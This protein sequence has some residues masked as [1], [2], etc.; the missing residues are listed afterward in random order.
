MP[1][2]SV[3]GIEINYEDKGSGDELVLIHNLTSNIE[4]LRQ[5]IAAFATRYRTIAADLRG[6]GLTT[7]ED[8]LERA[9]D[10][11]TFDNLANDQ[12]QLLDKLGV[13]RFF[14]FG[15][16]YWGANIALHLF[17]RI[18]DRVRAIVISSA[19]MISTDPGVKT[20][21]LLGET[22]R[23]N[24]IRMHQLARDKGMLAVYE[25]RKQYG[26]FWSEKVRTDPEILARFEDA[27]RHT[28]PAAFVT[29]PEISPGRRAAI[30]RLLRERRVPLMLLLGEHDQNNQQFI[31]EMRRDYPDTHTIII[32]GSGHYPT[33]ENAA[34]FNRA[35]LNFYARAA[36]GVSG[37]SV[38]ATGSGRSR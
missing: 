22:G 13:D 38:R 26:Q 18:P 9:P 23:N 33:I 4:G 31:D 25:D 30:A 16:A 32:P 12:V 5:N 2:A 24:F 36:A 6:H 17:E 19:Y 21:D 35:L 14:L 27:H 37:A 7:H 28:S 29:I 11:Y 20:Y 34:D 15:Q 10:F 8:S 3:N 1:R